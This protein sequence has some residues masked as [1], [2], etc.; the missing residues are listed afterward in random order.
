MTFNRDSIQVISFDAGGTLIVPH[1]SVG[2]VYAEVLAGHKITADPSQIE[3][4]FRTAFKQVKTR[5]DIVLD[6]KIWKEIVAISLADWEIQQFDEV[7]EE[8]WHTFSLPSRW[9]VLPEVES[10][11]KK[12]CEAGY[13]LI[14]L[15]N[16]DSRLE[17]VL[18]RLEL[19]S[20]FKKIYVSA[21][22][23]CEK[24]NRAIFDFVA[25]D[26]GV[27]PKAMLHVGDSQREDFEGARAA[28]WQSY[29]FEGTQ[30]PREL[31]KHFV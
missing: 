18:K 13:S 20:F 25:N 29:L 7:F 26:L 14:V 19:D 3:G 10:M 5:P 17:S 30:G 16:N 8:L 27:D 9:R 6:K 31:L 15:S 24:P 11:L 28:G 12:L 21:E 23:G 4:N 1:P 22:I 2:V